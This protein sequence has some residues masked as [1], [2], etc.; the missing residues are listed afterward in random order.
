MRDVMLIHHSSEESQLCAAISDWW[1]T[2]SFGSMFEGQASY[3]QKDTRAQTMLDSTTK[4]QDGRYEVGLLW[5][6]EDTK[7]PDNRKMAERR[8]ESLERSLSRDPTRAARYILLITCLATRAL[9]LEL[10]SSMDTDGF[11]M[12][13]RRFVARRGRPRVVWS[14]NGSNL[15][16]GEKELKVCL[17]EWNQEKIV[18][19]LSQRQIDWRFNPPNA[20]HKGGVW[21]RLVSS[22]KRALR[23]VLGNQCVSEEVL[24]TVL[25]EIEFVLN[26]RPLTYVS[27]DIGDPEPLTPNHFVLGYPEAAFPPGIFAESDVLGRGKW[28]Q[29]QA[30]A[31]QLWRRWQK[32]YLPL[33]IQRK[34]W[35]RETRDLQVGDVVLMVDQESPRGYWPLARIT[36]VTTSDDGRVRSVSLQTARG[37]VYRR[38][39]NKVCFLESCERSQ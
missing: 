19:E 6:Q 25:T 4:L 12:A 5:K 22:V 31:D 24:C 14:D 10:V 20:S 36:E 38:P 18:D 28:R 7:M 34:K 2:E 1:T 8:L 27:T 29:S 23:V 13:F 37:S 15:V 9:H 3:S 26:S 11:L 21:E 17:D 35:V 33:L 16:A 30:L 39:A 32:E